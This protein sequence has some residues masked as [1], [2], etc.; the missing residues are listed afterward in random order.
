MIRSKHLHV[1]GYTNNEL[2]PQQRRE[3]LVL[4]AEHATAGR[5]TVEHR[6]V[7]LAE[8]TDAWTR[9]GGPAASSSPL[10]GGAA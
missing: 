8:V 4:V 7:P 5:L 1:L 9:G 2:S 10:I 3:A 6:A